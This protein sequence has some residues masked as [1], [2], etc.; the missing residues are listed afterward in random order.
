MSVAYWMIVVMLL[1]PMVLAGIAKSQP[2]YDNARPREWLTQ[3]DGFRQRAHWAQLNTY[4]SLPG[5]F[6]AVI[7][8]HQLNATQLWIDGLA[9]GF[10]VF[11]IGYSWSYIN[12]R[13]GLRSLVWS[14][15][16]LCV[17]GL[18]ALAALTGIGGPT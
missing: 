6:A 7:I 10:V 18:F 8:A 11:R 15:A 9:L 5:F 3:L 4:E 16:L 14:A 13:P 12:D 17:L 2:G 1:M